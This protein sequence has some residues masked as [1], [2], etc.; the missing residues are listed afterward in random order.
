MRKTTLP[1]PDVTKA[2][3]QSLLKS[4]LASYAEIAA[5]SGRSRQIVWFW[6]KNSAPKRLARNTS[7][8]C[9]AIP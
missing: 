8:S 7:R 6:A 3:A 4:G 5:I 9:G 2:A 1:D